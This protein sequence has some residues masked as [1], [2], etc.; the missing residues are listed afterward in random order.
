M[1]PSKRKILDKA[2]S[3]F[4]IKNYDS[5]S[6]KDI[7]D[8]SETSRGSIYHHFRSKEEIYEEVVNEYL[9]PLFFTYS[10]TPDEEKR[11]LQDTI[12]GAIKHQQNH[13]NSLKEIVPAEL[14]DFYFFKFV[15]QASEHSKKFK[16]EAGTL[17]EKEYNGWRNIIQAAMRSGEIR[18][19]IDIDYASQ[20]FISTPFG[21][22][23][24]KAFNTVNFNIGDLRTTYLKLYALLKKTSIYG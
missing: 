13:I 17:V 15:F 19:D 7:Q 23:M 24:T 3:L 22:G 6:L 9:L 10:Y 16:E 14:V 12:L 5:V 2:F 4:L 21:L 8:L 1:S 20:W 18:A 11:T